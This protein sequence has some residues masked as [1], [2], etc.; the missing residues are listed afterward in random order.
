[1]I[2][3]TAMFEEHPFS[4]PVPGLPSGPDKHVVE[5]FE[6]SEDGTRIVIDYEFED[7]EY[8]NEP[9][10]GQVVWYYAPHLEMLGFDCDP[11]NARRFTVQ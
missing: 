1:M 10:V 6:L 9:F 2:V 5:R 8:L 3:D 7:P 11:E 4:T